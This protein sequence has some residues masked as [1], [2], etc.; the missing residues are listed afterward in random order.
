MVRT[1][2]ALYHQQDSE[3]SDQGLL[4]VPHSSL[5]A[6]ADCAFVVVAPLWNTVD[7][8]KKQLRLAFTTFNLF[9]IYFIDYFYIVL[10]VFV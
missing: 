2:A 10:Y 5:R 8:F 6:N 3:S 1:T 4:V 9:I 7:T